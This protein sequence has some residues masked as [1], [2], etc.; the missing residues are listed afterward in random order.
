MSGQSE[1]S[2]I[3]KNAIAQL[4]AL[5]AL[6]PSLPVYDAHYQAYSGQSANKVLE[7]YSEITTDAE[8]HLVDFVRSFGFNGTAVPVSKGDRELFREGRKDARSDLTF[9]ALQ[10]MR[11]AVLEAAE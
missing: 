8:L 4:T 5:D 11:E 2:A 6:L 7:K 9:D 10:S 3:L 1:L